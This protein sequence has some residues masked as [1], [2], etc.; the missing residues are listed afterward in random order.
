ML[1]SPRSSRS[2]FFKIC[3]FLILVAL[4]FG[5]FLPLGVTARA[6]RSVPAR[7]GN[8]RPGAPEGEFPNLNQVKQRPQELPLTPPPIPSTMRDRKLPLQ[9]WDGRRVGDPLT[10]GATQPERI[11]DVESRRSNVQLKANHARVRRAIEPPLPDD[12]FIQNFFSWA[13]LRSPDATESTFWNDQL[14]RGYAHGQESLTLA[15]VE[16]GK[17]LFESADYAARNRD[18][19]WYVYDLY[20]TFLMRD[21][22]PSGWA[23]WESVVPT[24]GRENVRRAFEVCSEFAT[25]LA[26]VTP[27]GSASSNA[28][29]LITARVDPRNQPANGLLTRDAVWSFPLLSLPG[30]SGLDLGLTLSYSSMVWTRSGPYIHFDEDNGSPSPGFRLGFPSIQRKVFDAQTNA[31]SFLM[32]TSSGSRVELRQGGT[33][34]VY[35]AGDSSYLQLTDGGAGLM[36]L[37]S[38]DGTQLTYQEYNNEWRCI[39]AKDRNGNY[40]TVHHNGLG[41]ITTITDTLGRTITFNYDGNANLLSITDVW[42]GQ[43]HTWATFGWGT[44]AGRVSVRCE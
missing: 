10:L 28:A 13:V 5:S 25:L 19:H 11:K 18:N 17:T 40:L 35:E 34:N 9:P 44:Q 30:R 27:N 33:S 3:T 43:T 6:Q 41:Q 26:T 12:T 7:M 1:T 29:S 24:N 32:I 16:L 4:V 42:N 23:Y 36:T 8:P 39:E 15:A 20:K 37:R 22:D 21:P 31:N 14:R 2:R 38:T